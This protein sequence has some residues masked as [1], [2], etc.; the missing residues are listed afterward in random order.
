MLHNYEVTT[1]DKT[2]KNLDAVKSSRIDQISAKFLKDG[3]LVTTIHLANI[4]NL[5]I[6]LNTFPSKCKVA[7]KTLCLEKE[8]RLKLKS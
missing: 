5:S 4:T 2:L 7:K 1:V 6:T 8:L 3:A